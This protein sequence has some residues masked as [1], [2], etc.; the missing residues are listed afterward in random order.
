MSEGLWLLGGY[1]HCVEDFFDGLRLCD[2]RD[3]LD[4]STTESAQQRVDFVNFLNHFCPAEPSLSVCVAFILAVLA[5]FIG[6]LSSGLSAAFC[7]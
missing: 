5:V 2:E 7:A 3:D 1:V 6:I 4:F